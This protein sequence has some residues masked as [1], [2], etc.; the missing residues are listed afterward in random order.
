MKKFNSLSK[1]IKLNDYLIKF[2]TYL[3]LIFYKK[4]KLSL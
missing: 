3:K 4:Y 1:Y 2:F